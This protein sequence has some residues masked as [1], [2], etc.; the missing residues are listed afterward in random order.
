[1]KIISLK[2]LREKRETS[3]KSKSRAKKKRKNNEIT[4]SV[5]KKIIF[6]PQRDYFYYTEVW[7]DWP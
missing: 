5:L 3:K 1:M 7:K 6:D 4:P 2:E